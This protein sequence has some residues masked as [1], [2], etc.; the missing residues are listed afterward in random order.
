MSLLK[1]PSPGVVL[2][3]YP[4]KPKTEP[5]F[6][7]RLKRKLQTPFVVYGST[8]VSQYQAFIQQIAAFA[9][10]FQ[11]VSEAKIKERLRELQGLLSM[12]G[13]TDSLLAE[14]FAII[15]K[16]CER[17]L[18]H[19]PYDT[20]LIAAR[21]MLD[22][23][24]AEMA[25]GEGKTLAAGICVAAAALAGIPVHLITSNDYLVTRDA[26]SLSPLHRALGLSVGTVVQGMKTEERKQAYACNITYVTAKELVFDYLRDR[27]SG[28]RARTSL[29]H[30]V[31]QLSGQTPNTFLRGLYMA[32]IDEADSILIDEARVPLILSQSVLQDAQVEYHSTIFALA[33]TLI[34][35]QDFVL[36]QRILSAELTESGLQKLYAERQK[37][38]QLSHNKMHLEETMCQALA[39][40]Y[41]FQRDKHYL[42]RDDAVHIIDEITGRISPGRV[43]SRGLHQLIELKEHCKPSGEM[44]TAAQITYQRFFP[45]YLRLG[46]MSGTLSESRAELFSLFDLKIVKVPLRKPS[47]RVILPTRIYRDRPALWAAVTKRVIALHKN[48]HPILIGTDSVADSEV[49]SEQLKQAGL[50]HE[51]LNARQ[52]QR[53]ANI[54]AQAGQAKQITVS[55]NIAGRGTDIALGNGVEALGGIH[56]ISC[57]H[58]PSRRIDRQLIG[59]CARQG[60][61]G[62]AETLISMDKPLIADLFPKWVIKLAGK[63]GFSRPQWLVMLVLRLPQWLEEA[64]QRAQRQEMMQ[65]DARI[66]RQSSL[67][68]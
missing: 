62:V 35:Q 40:L 47:Q 20:Q 3:N 18:G 60:K 27:T 6:V 41:L 17:E 1:A 28:S 10:D 39:A 42:V 58:N 63:S 45:R 36:N 11:H 32:I 26:E 9:P 59:R 38:G 24:L 8:S 29:H 67:P 54:V 53:E 49:L 64:H 21:I 16:T 13:F 44:V 19:I 30:R 15:K 22:G 7:A 37:L 33:S 34:S 4:E 12:H 43:W 25:T 56:L 50:A 23:K 2:G 52:D 61:P 68:E 57:Q 46:G 31:A 65:H 66:E 5:T 14:L 51:V 48:G 55:T